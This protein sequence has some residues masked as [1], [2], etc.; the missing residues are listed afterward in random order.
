[1]ARVAALVLLLAAAS[2]LTDGAPSQQ[3]GD[4]K[5][6][7][8]YYAS[9]ATYRSNGG[10]LT[11]AQIDG[12]LCNHLIY[13]FAGLGQDGTATPLDKYADLCDNYGKCG[14]KN[15]NDLK[16]KNP[17]LKTSLAIGGWN[18]GSA[19]Y[20]QMAGDPAKRLAFINSAVALAKQHN[21]DGIDMDWEYPG[22]RGGMPTDAVNFVTLLQELGKALRAESKFLSIAAG[23]TESIIN[24]GYPNAAN[25][26]SAVDYIHVMA[27]SFHGTWEIGTNHPSL[28][29]S[30]GPGHEDS[31][32]Q[33]SSMALWLSKGADK[34]KLI[35]GMSLSGACWKLADATKN[36]MYAGTSGPA[37]AGPWLQAPGL[38]AYNE[39]CYVNKT[40]PWTVVHDPKMHEPYAY[41][42]AYYNTWCGYED[43]QSFA[44]K[45]K[46]VI[47]SGFAGM[48][49][50][51]VDNDDFNGD[52][53]GGTWPLLKAAQNA[54]QA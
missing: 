26:S 19:A 5:I 31:L 50:W 41:N 44:V 6:L 39:M 10:G 40:L 35:L 49:V 7:S 12:S 25:V 16:T 38:M 46:Y 27:Y 20:S 45:A 22:S 13:A 2:S 24:A 9:W 51:S 28:L 47:D 53:G 52:C 14:Y 32:N 21:F 1:M 8:C 4:E 23:A 33:N 15:F 48:S 37:R 34:A 42:A 18:E 30:Y 36:G 29:Y 43:P 17:K 54:F 11:P 3:A